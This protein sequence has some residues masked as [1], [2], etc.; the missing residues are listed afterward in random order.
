MSGYYNP[1]DNA[2]KADYC[3]GFDSLHLIDREIEEE[4][5]IKRTNP[6]YLPEVQAKRR[7]QW[8]ANKKTVRESDKSII[9]MQQKNDG[10]EYTLKNMIVIALIAFMCGML[11]HWMFGSK[12]GRYREIRVGYQRCLLDTRTGDISEL[13]ISK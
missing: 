3:V 13:K 11:A 4:D 1:L 12:N 5:R 2:D 6:D 9:V 10:R 7:E 8:L